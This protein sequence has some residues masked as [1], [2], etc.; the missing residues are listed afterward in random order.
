MDLTRENYV[1]TDLHSTNL[2]TVSYANLEIPYFQWLARGECAA[3][4]CAFSRVI[5]HGN[6]ASTGSNVFL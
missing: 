1:F 6:D 4:V 3:S 2:G 5:E